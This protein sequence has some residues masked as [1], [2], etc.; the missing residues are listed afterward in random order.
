MTTWKNSDDKSKIRFFFQPDV[1]IRHVNGSST[2]F[3]QHLAKRFHLIFFDLRWLLSL[4]LK[5]ENLISFLN[6]VNYS[7]FNQRCGPNGIRRNILDWKVE[8]TIRSK[9]IKLMIVRIHSRNNTLTATSFE[10]FPAILG[11]FSKSIQIIE[12]SVKIFEI[13]EIIFS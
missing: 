1:F 5:I 12:D 6:I 3:H 9:V 10:L 7:L 11:L 4:R 8:S 2:I 13:P